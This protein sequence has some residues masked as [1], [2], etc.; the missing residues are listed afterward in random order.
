LRVHVPE[1]RAREVLLGLSGLAFDFLLQEEYGDRSGREEMV[2]VDGQSMDEV[3]WLARRVPSGVLGL[4]RRWRGLGV[5]IR[6]QGEGPNGS[7][8]I[9]R[10]TLQPQ[11]P[12]L[13]ELNRH[14]IVRQHYTVHGLPPF[15][16]QP[17]TRV[18]ASGTT[19][20]LGVVNHPPTELRRLEW[21]L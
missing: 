4:A 9:A 20:L 16:G 3:R 15:W 13:N 7:V 8:A 21:I 12:Y 18:G 19:A 1:G 5:R 17:G 11:D 2:W 6:V 10:A 14:V